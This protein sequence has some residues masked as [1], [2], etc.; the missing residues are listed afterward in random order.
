MKKEILWILASL[1]I[2]IISSLL[3]GFDGN[4]SIDI[5]IHDTYFVLERWTVITL[6]FC[7]SL[8]II[9]VVRCFAFRFRRTPTNVILMLALAG[10][11]FIFWNLS[12]L[13]SGINS[14]WTEYPPLSS[15]PEEGQPERDVFSQLPM[16]I[17]T[18]L[19]LLNLGLVVVAFVSGLKM[20]NR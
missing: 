13:F 17:N 9:F 14:G 16:A 18:I 5:N 4:S 19:L 3:L 20:K 12:I 6:L 7:V 1:L 8:S 2:A 10:L 15:I 11:V